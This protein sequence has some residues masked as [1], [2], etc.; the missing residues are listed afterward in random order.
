VKGKARRSLPRTVSKR[1]VS[2]R[3]KPA[4]ESHTLERHRGQEEMVLWLRGTRN[5]EKLDSWQLGE[6]MSDMKRM[7]GIGKEAVR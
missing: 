5:G 7:G 4:R 3:T 6:G 2:S 1:K